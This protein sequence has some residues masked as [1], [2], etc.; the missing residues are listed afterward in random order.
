MRRVTVHSANLMAEQDQ[1][2]P[3]AAD[4]APAPGPDAGA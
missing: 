3:F 2:L 1:L 4:A